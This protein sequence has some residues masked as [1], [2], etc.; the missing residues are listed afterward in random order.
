MA[1]DTTFNFFIDS[2]LTTPFSGLAQYIH[3]TSLSDNPQDLTLYLGSVALA[4]AYQL[5]ASSNPG[6]DQIT[7]TPTD[8]LPEW[9]VATVYA[10]GDSI[11]PT[12]GNTYRYQVTTA[13][14]SHAT[15]EPT[16]PTTIG[17]T[18]TDNTV[19]WTCMSKVHPTTEVK[20]ALTSGGLAGATPGGALNLG[21]EILSGTANAIEFHMRITNTVTTVGD[22]VGTPEITVYLNTCQED[23]V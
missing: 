8:T 3:N 5:R 10:L 9:S 23:A 12:T 14:T 13:G 17:D 6:T 4:D 7:L 20:L 19:T 1:N 11:Q 22:N 18:V 21:T 2:G 15:T 16:W